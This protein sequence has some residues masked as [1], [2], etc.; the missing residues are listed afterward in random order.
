MVPINKQKQIKI[1]KEKSRHFLDSELRLLYAFFSKSHAYLFFILLFVMIAIAILGVRLSHGINEPFG[2]ESVKNLHYAN[3][4]S[5]HSFT[6]Y[7]L[8]P[9]TDELSLHPSQIS[10]NLFT[11][12]LSKVLFLPHIVLIFINLFLALCGVLIFSKILKRNGVSIMGRNLAVFLTLL[13][14][15]FIYYALSISI[16]PLA[17]LLF[18]SSMFFMRNRKLRFIS[19]L[20]SVIIV[21]LGVKLT[22]AYLISVLVFS[23]VQN[24]MKIFYTILSIQVVLLGV[25][26]YFSFPFSLF[27]FPLFSSQMIITEM[28][29]DFGG[30]RGVGAMVIALFMFGFTRHI[31]QKQAFLLEVTSLFLVIAAFFYEYRIFFFVNFM[32][33]L[34]ASDSLTYLFQSKWYSEYLKAFGIFVIL[35]GVIFT[36]VSYANRISDLEPVAA[37]LDAFQWLSNKKAGVVFTIPEKASFVQTYANKSILIDESQYSYS[38]NTDINTILYTTNLSETKE[39]LA[40]YNVAYIYVDG[41][42]KQKTWRKFDDGLLFTLRNPETFKRIYDDVGI[43]IWSVSN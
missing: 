29:A 34:L 18:M 1:A 42:M 38:I 40:K 24:R 30:L 25:L 27:P 4:L 6:S 19:Y 41:N 12:L 33:C 39:L 11:I 13:S 14:P 37:Q 32:I 10:V 26:S 9:S 20:L 7:F 23:I 43:E 21:T 28:V 35:C 17:S 36:T 16:L 2:Y 8:H 5:E 15:I 3:Q 22:L 31:I